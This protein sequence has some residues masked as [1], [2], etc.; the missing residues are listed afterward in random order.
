MEK[1]DLRN[2]R[3][4]KRDERIRATELQKEELRLLAEREA[5]HYEVEKLTKQHSRMK[6]EYQ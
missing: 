1:Y 3:Q 5:T 6:S 4:V 2:T